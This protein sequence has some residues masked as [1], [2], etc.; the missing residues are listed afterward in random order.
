MVN[1]KFIKCVPEIMFWKYFEKNNSKVILK[2]VKWSF[3]RMMGCRKSFGE[4]QGET[5]LAFLYKLHIF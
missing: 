1:P 2:G 4:V 3:M 5:A